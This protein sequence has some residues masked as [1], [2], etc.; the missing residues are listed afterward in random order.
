MHN[1]TLCALLFSL[2]YIVGTV[3]AA[4]SAF[5]N[6]PLTMIV[7]FNPGGSTDI[8]AKAL[9]PVL[10]D[11]LG[12]P[13]NILYLPGAGGGLAAAMLASSDEEG[14]VFMFGTSL[15]Y[16]F[17]PL[18]A[19]ASYNINSFRYVAALALDQ[20]AIVTGGVKPFKTWSEFIEYGQGASS[21]TV[22]SQTP[23]DRY[24]LNMISQR[25]GLNLRVVPTTGGAG[26]TPL[27]L[28]GDVD[29]AFSGG[30]HTQYTESGDMVVLLSLVDERLIGYPDVPSLREYGYQISLQNP[31]VVAVPSNTPD[32]QVGILSHALQQ[33][34]LDP[35]F[36][37]ATD[38]VRLPVVF[39]DEQEVTEYFDRQMEEY[40]WLINEYGN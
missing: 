32:N 39:Y 13:V 7:G 5:P 18:T 25:E 22:A 31:R 28:S 2:L 24:L 40:L 1:K 11:V 30:T 3:N 21:L 34:T 23:Q 8:Q 14:Y 16:T 9:A 15:P 33:A 27:I 37:A 19:P 29:F 17:T 38:R 4:E 20:S 35:R 36:I 10:E 6:R 12:Q 26:M